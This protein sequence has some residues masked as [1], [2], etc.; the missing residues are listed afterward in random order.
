MDINIFLKLKSGEYKENVAFEEI[1]A[2]YQ[3]DKNLKIIFLKYILEFELIIKSKI[4]N[5][6][7]EKYGI[8]DYLKADN[9]DLNHKTKHLIDILVETIRQEIN[10]SYTKH[11]AIEHYFKKYGFVPLYVGIKIMTLGLVS[12]F[13][14]LMKQSDRQQISKSFG[15]SDS[16][17]KQILVN[18]TSIRNICA[19]SDRL[20]CYRSKF[21]ISAKKVDA[22]HNRKENVTNLYIIIKSME[23]IMEKEKY[24]MFKKELNAEI[25]ILKK[26]LKSINI[27]DVLKVMGFRV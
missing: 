5:L 15:I 24:E 19:H 13:Y 4:A 23:F 14:G 27:D 2:L 18:I 25:K 3:F 8:N 12:R 21:Y 10:N 17:L 6:F 20:F 11:S 22:N 7:T 26:Q 16:L 1:F 9:F